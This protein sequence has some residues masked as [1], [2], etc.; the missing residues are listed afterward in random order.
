[1]SVGNALQAADKRQNKKA[2]I[3]DVDRGFATSNPGNEPAM[4]W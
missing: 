1:V 4:G 2:P 3:N